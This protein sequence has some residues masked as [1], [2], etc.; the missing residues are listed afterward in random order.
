MIDNKGN[1]HNQ[2]FYQRKTTYKSYISIEETPL[3]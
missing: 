1:E 2:N 3:L